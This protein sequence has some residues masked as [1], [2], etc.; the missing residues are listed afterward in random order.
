M[1]Y[2]YPK[3]SPLVMI[4][5]EQVKDDGK[6]VELGSYRLQSDLSTSLEGTY[7]SPTPRIC[8]PVND[9]PSRGQEL[10]DFA[11]TVYKDGL[12]PWQQ[13]V[14][15]H[16]HKVKP[17]GRWAHPVNVAITARQ[18]GKSTFMVARALMGLFHWDESLQ[19]MSSHNLNGSKEQFRQM[20]ALIEGNADLSKHIKRI[21]WSNGAEEIET[22]KGTRFVIKA[23][24][25]AARGL[26]KPE[27]IHLDE[28][29]E[30][31]ELKSFAA[32]RFTVLAA[33]NPMIFA[34]STAG[35]AT[36]LVLNK[37][38]ER[39]LAAAAGAADDIGYFEW[40]APTNEVNLESNWLAANPAIGHTINIDNIKAT[41]NDFP[42]KVMTEVLCRWVETIQG[43]VN[44]A[45][46]ESCADDSVDLELDKLTWLALDTSPDRKHCALVGAQKL[47]EESFVVKL[48]HTWESAQPLDDR[49]IAND[50]AVYCRKY[51]IEHLLYSKR[52][53]GAV[54]ARLQPA[55][56][57]TYDMDGQY[58]QACDEMMGA[59]NSG[60]LKHR[61]QQEL[62]TQMLSAVKLIKGDSS[63]VIGRRATQKAVCAAV[64]VALATHFATRPE[65]EIDILVG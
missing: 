51:S 53:S 59:I 60:R 3:Q 42:E 32:L 56:I 9:L 14:A 5:G 45:L 37:F 13:Y 46:W 40:S 62:T 48:L 44:P 33:K 8:S 23:G 1:M 55:G 54:A 10:I 2:L 57:S 50:A 17:D 49:A 41:M 27:T 61:S 52:T 26:S 4:K 7:G 15:I 24:G 43:V 63:W 64:A 6:V 19:I 25:S 35:D 58:P 21:W 34:Y 39:G 28:L 30:M 36:S 18:S 16:A 38:R 22:S 65:T 29:L 47:G 20:V 11:A 31:K 12:M